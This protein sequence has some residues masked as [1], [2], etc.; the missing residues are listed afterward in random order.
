MI[1][2]GIRRI[3]LGIGGSL[4]CFRNGGYGDVF[5]VFFVV[6]FLLLFEDFALVSCCSLV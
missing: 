1:V 6:Q 3:L 5:E 2:M 4:H